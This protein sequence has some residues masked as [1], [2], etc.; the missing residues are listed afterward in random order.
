MLRKTMLSAVTALGALA[1]GY[2]SANAATVNISTNPGTTLETTALAGFATSGDMMKGMVVSVTFADST[3]QNATWD[4]TGAGAGG[5]TG[6]GFTIAESG[7]TFGANWTLA[8]TSTQAIIGFTLDGAPGSTLFDRD[9]N[10]NGS[11]G[12]PG[13]AN[14]S[15]FSISAPADIVA[16]VTYT[17]QTAIKG[18]APVGDIW[19]F[20]AVSI[21]GNGLAAD[22]SLVFSQ[23]TDSLAEPGDITPG[24]PIPL[25]AGAGP[26]LILLGVVGLL[27]KARRFLPC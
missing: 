3:T 7:N 12:T 10:G 21:Q 18:T 6:T 22:T 11:E 17:N 16:D 9:F 24:T 27:A 1:L 23:D 25:P 4:A 26:G 19:A 5:A 2:G 13:S 14:G 15:D 8:N 20:L